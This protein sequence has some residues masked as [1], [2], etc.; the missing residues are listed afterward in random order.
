MLCTQYSVKSRRVVTKAD[1]ASFF[2]HRALGLPVETTLWEHTAFAV[3]MVWASGSDL[4]ASGQTLLCCGVVLFSGMVQVRICLCTFYFAEFF[5]NLGQ[6]WGSSCHDRQETGREQGRERG[7]IYSLLKGAP[8][9][10][11]SLSQ[12]PL[13]NVSTTSPK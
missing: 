11:M 5:L 1:S 13:A 7:H 2:P 6:Q 4:W 9:R 8:L 10:P 3:L 12:T